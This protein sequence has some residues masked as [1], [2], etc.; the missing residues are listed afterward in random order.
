[1]NNRD[2]VNVATSILLIGLSLLRGVILLL[3]APPAGCE[4]V[5][6]A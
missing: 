6:S 2:W 1:L 4:P 5:V 3:A